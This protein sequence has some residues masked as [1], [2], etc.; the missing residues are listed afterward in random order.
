[1]RKPALPRLRRSDPP[2]RRRHGARVAADPEPA[3]RAL[4][5]PGVGLL[6]TR[7]G[8]G[9]D[10]LEE[11]V[12]TDPLE[13]LPAGSCPSL[14]RTRARAPPSEVPPG[15][16]RRLRRGGRRSRS[17]KSCTN[18]AGSRSSR[19]RAEEDPDAVAAK[20]R[21]AFGVPAEHGARSVEGG[22]CPERCRDLRPAQ[23]DAA[24]A[25][26]APAGGRSDPPARRACRR[27]RR[28][29]RRA[30]QPE[31]RSRSSIGRLRGAGRRRSSRA[32][33][34]HVGRRASR[35]RAEA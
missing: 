15:R 7:A 28:S 16:R 5:D 10:D 26:R 9:D 20:S 31:R 21:E 18:S 11:T 27:R 13:L 32:P 17:M 8:R 4:E 34:P 29:R 1:M 25:Q 19:Q 23:V 24:C 35:G 6:Y 14:R 12:D 22:L 2:P 3:E 33:R 30:V